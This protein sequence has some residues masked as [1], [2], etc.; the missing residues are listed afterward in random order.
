MVL[1]EIIDINIILKSIKV[2]EK[3]YA[4]VFKQ[5]GYKF[6]GRYHD[7][8]F[9]DYYYEDV[10]YKNC[11]VSASGEL[12]K[13]TQGTP[14]VLISGN[15]GFGDFIVLSVFDKVVCDYIKSELK[16]KFSFTL[17]EN[18][19]GII[20]LTNKNV[21]VDISKDKGCYSFTFRLKI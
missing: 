1:N 14:S 3:N 13:I 16:N 7:H 2:H 10:F 11:T 15:L 5:N 17:L 20:T 19:N 18:D 6:K 8:N 4:Y 21:E 9:A 12:R